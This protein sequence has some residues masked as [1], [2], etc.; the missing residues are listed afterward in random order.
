MIGC[1]I[2]GGQY[3]RLV[4]TGY[5]GYDLRGL[6]V[7]YAEAASDGLEVYAECYAYEDVFPA[8]V[9]KYLPDILFIVVGEG[10]C[11]EKGSVLA[12]QHFAFNLLINSHICVKSL[13][14]FAKNSE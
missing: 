2:A 8:Q 6:G 4:S 13:G 3:L 11:E 9:G 14:N 5:G 7:D 10:G 12:F 1:G